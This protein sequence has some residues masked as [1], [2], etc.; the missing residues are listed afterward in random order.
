MSIKS[1]SNSDQGFYYCG[2]KEEQSFIMDRIKLNVI[3]RTSLAYTKITTFYELISTVTST[4]TTNR[5]ITL[6]TSE[7]IIQF[8]TNTT[9]KPDTVTTIKISNDLYIKCSQDENI[10]WNGGACYKTNP[11]NL[12]SDTLAKKFCM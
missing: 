1:V 4:T 11:T 12:Q 5:S 9:N 7:P 6:T 2:I 10:C 3:D 8:Y